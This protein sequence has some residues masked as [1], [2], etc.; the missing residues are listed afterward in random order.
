MMQ[1][2]DA[3]A[4]RSKLKGKDALTEL[5]TWRRT[6]L[7][8]AIHARSPP[9]MTKNE[10]VRLV[11]CK[12]TR[13]IRRPGYK[14]VDTN[15]SPE[16]VMEVT[17][18]AYSMNDLIESMTKLCDLNQVG[19]ATA[20]YIL[21]AHIPHSVPIMSDE[22]L[23]QY[24]GKTEYTIKGFKRLLEAMGD[25]ADAVALEHAACIKAWSA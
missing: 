12:M 14:K 6:E 10:L 11:E 2:E 25:D 5:D 16:S 21:A 17:K 8:Q 19:P 13:G 18:A 22:M 4:A 1:Y 9:Y 3:L 24:L 15:N 20:S 23:N 7:P